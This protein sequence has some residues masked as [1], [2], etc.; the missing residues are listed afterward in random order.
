MNSP[1]TWMG[2]KSKLYKEIINIMPEHTTYV[3]PFAGGLWVFFNK[4]K[5][6]V[7]VVNDVNSELVNFYKVIQNNYEELKNKCKFLVSSR[8]IFYENSR[9]AKEEIDKLSSIDRAV[10]FLYVNR[11]SFGG[12]MNGYGFKNA[13]RPNLSCITDDFDKTIGEIHKRFK[14]VYIENGDYKEIIKRYDSRPTQVEK[15]E[16]LFYFDPP[17]IETSGYD[18][19]F[20]NQNHYELAEQIKKLNSKFILSINNHPLVYELYEGFNFI[21]KEIKTK[22]ANQDN[23][24][25][26]KELI[27]TNYNTSLINKA[28]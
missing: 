20:T 23:S 6:R 17:Y 15:Q 9:M 2:G 1:I 5:V 13:R 21:N 25:T 19:D 26:Q 22:L 18:S 11:C 4:P 14:D 27:I 10:R 8:E 24:R 12:K 16:V 7:E 3:E 28:L